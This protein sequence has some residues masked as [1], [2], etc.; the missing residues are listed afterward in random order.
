M[1]K[2]GVYLPGSIRREDMEEIIGDFPHLDPMFIEEMRSDEVI[3]HA[4]KAK[5][6]GCDLFIARGLQAE[7]LQ[8]SVPQVPVLPLRL[9]AQEVGLIVMKILKDTGE[10][11]SGH[12]V[13][14]RLVGY[15]N[16]YPDVSHFGEFFGADIETI[17]LGM[18]DS[19][20]DVL[21]QAKNA[22][23]D[24]VIG[25]R[26]C[27][28]AAQQLGIPAYFAASGRESIRETLVLA[29]KMGELVDTRRFDDAR[30]DAIVANNFNGILHVDGDGRILSANRM[31]LQFLDLPEEKVEGRMA[32]DLLKDFDPD[33]LKEAVR[34]GKE[35]FSYMY[36]MGQTVYAVNLTPILSDEKVHGAYLTF[37]EGR[38][39]RQLSSDIRREIVRRGYVAPGK[40]EDFAGVKSQTMKRVLRTAQKTA[41]L[42]APVLI[43][44]PG[45]CERDRLAMSMHNA[46]PMR[47]NPFVMVNCGA[48]RPEQLERLLF[49]ESDNQDSRGISLME[50]ASEGTLYLKNVEFLPI[51]AQNRLAIYLQTG[52]VTAVDGQ[53]RESTCRVIASTT[54]DLA[55][56][57]MK[58]NFSVP[59]YYMLSII[60]LDIPPICER[61]EDILPY[62]DLFMNQYQK[63]YNRLI[64]LTQGARD[65]LFSYDWP[66]NVTQ[67]RQVAQ[68]ILILCEHREAS[69]LFVRSLLEKSRAVIVENGE[70]QV[71][72]FEDRKAREITTLLEKY[73]GNREMVA[74]ELG[75]S[76][77][78]LW[79]YMKKYGV[80]PPSEK[81]GQNPGGGD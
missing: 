81:R 17:L 68:R 9:T 63:E 2:I 31:M 44:S 40:F 59:L 37:Q 43:V 12:P 50:A 45:G 26:H 58:G 13:R 42:N 35:V 36:R 64:R 46:S 65:A 1:A 15:A 56:E 51:T 69:E 52:T 62:V 80:M 29:E 18:K 38:T 4:I 74:K 14:I 25:G 73:Q 30:T 48:Y 41:G 6:E 55:E 34:E 66:G 47:T 70:K 24:V 39:I 33:T 32:L 53:T 72:T 22:G 27:C 71:V 23:A 67:I 54:R 57:A 79:R 3:S 7:T 76:K 77:T 5:A 49:E 11:M 75:I 10:T 20:R 21:I 19:M 61:R 60:R 28:Q 8:E 78:T 16:M